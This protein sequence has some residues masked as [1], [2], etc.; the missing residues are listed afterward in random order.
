MESD[1][2]Y[3]YCT[4]FDTNYIIKGIVMLLSLIQ[5]S[6]DSKI[7]VLALDEETKKII[8]DYQFRNV[9]VINLSDFIDSASALK[10]EKSNTEFCWSCSA[11]L[12]RYV[13]D[14][15]HEEYCTYID[16]DMYFYSD[17][18]CLIDEMIENKKC[19]QIMEH[20]FTP[21][22]Y[23]K[24]CLKNFG[25]FCVEFNT[26][27]NEKKSIEVLEDW[28]KKVNQCCMETADGTVFGDQ[29]YLDDW[30]KQFDCINICTNIFAGVAPWNVGQY[31]MV[32][33]ENNVPIIKHRSDKTIKPL[34][35]YHFHG[36]EELEDGVVDI[37]VHRVHWNV[38][39]QLV[40]CIY[41][42]YFKELK[43]VQEQLLQKY[44]ETINIF[45]RRVH[46]QKTFTSELRQRFSVHYFK[47]ILWNIEMRVKAIKAGRKDIY[48]V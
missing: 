42:Q 36:I 24:N 48:R 10:K 22:R 26:F 39:C 30:P 20:R 47:N 4:L 46:V 41:N 8:S 45:K 43:K 1:V 29:K 37:A 13:F 34:I 44:G 23:G 38:D 32:K 40:D 5:C 11:N 6:Q 9:I 16:A 17:P 14:H 25:R 31:C 12:I 2:K 7:Y 19:V 27:C 21:D 33:K 15:Y 3:V 35:F 18:S 28:I